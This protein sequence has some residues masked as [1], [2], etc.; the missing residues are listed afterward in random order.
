MFDSDLGLELLRLQ[1]IKH[2][3]SLDPSNVKDIVILTE[4]TRIASRMSRLMTAN[5]DESIIAEHS[6]IIE[7]SRFDF[8]RGQ[9]CGHGLFRHS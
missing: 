5:H 4:D 8:G 7:D 6:R 3:L 2:T 1:S 9:Q